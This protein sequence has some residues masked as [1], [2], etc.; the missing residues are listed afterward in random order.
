MEKFENGDLDTFVKGIKHENP[1]LVAA[2]FGCFKILKS[3]IQLGDSTQEETFNFDDCND[4]GETLL[5]LGI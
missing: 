3:I 4:N 5:H 1:L 2:E